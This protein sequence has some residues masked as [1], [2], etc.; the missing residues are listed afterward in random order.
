VRGAGRPGVVVVLAAGLFFALATMVGTWPVFSRPWAAIYDPT[1]PATDLQ[2][3][4]F[5]AGRHGMWPL[6]TVEGEPRPWGFLR[7]ADSLLNIWTLAWGAHALVTAPGRFFDANT[8]FPTPHSLTYSDHQIG[9]LPWFA[10][11]YWLTGNPVLAYQGALFLSAVTCGL[12]FFLLVHRWTGSTSAGLVAGLASIFAPFHLTSLHLLIHYTMQYIPAALLCVDAL[13][14][15]RRRV[16]AAAGLVACLALQAACSVYMVYVTFLLVPAYALGALLETRTPDK[17]RALPWM[18]IAGT[19]AAALVIAAYRPY[20][21]H[22]ESGEFAARGPR[23]GQPY[24]LGLTIS[25]ML[26]GQTQSGLIVG[27]LGWPLLVVAGL[28]LLH[29]GARRRWTLLGVVLFGLVLAVGP[30]FR[31]EP[32]IIEYMPWAW[33]ARWIPGFATQRHLYVPRFLVGTGLV[34][35]VGLGWAWLMGVLGRRARA[36]GAVLAVAILAATLH[37]VT[38]SRP[39]LLYL[40]AGR[41]VPEAYRWLAAN[42]DGAPLLELPAR[43]GV[44]T[45]YAY[46]ST[47]HWLPLFN[48]GYAFAPPGYQE[49]LQRAFGVLSHGGTTFLDDVPVRWILVHGSLLFPWQFEEL[50]HPPPHL[51][52]AARF[53]TDVIFRVRRNPSP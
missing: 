8:L 41:W 36:V 44:N 50:T 33:L 53:G 10:P 3:S 7:R 30:V 22:V 25:W 31:W 17:R 14:A 29:A 46:F 38:P 11:T 27:S 19:V 47:Y 26:P 16:L 49:R 9:V 32:V 24:S 18:L 6:P 15:G 12:A 48:G 42:G 1:H 4:A 34:C 52:E 2:L 40:A 5:L 45:A 21:T 20:L 51:E 35:L 13:L 23:P 39:L 43:L 37:Q 28:G